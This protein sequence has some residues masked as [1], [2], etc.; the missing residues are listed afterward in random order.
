MAKEFIVPGWRVGWLS[1]VDRSPS[2]PGPQ[3]M[4]EVKAGLKS[5]SQLILGACSL[6]Q[7]AIPRILTPAPGSADQAAL[8]K[9][10]TFYMDLIRTNSEICL[11]EAAKVP[12]LTAVPAKGAMYVM[13]HV[14]I[15]KLTGFT[16]DTDFCARLLMEEN[17][18]V[19]PGQCFGMPNYFR[20]VTCPPSELLLEAWE[21]L[22]LFCAKYRK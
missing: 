8:Q 22:G 10:N 5:L 13:V 16:D 18:F 6:V 9:F 7:R 14:D 11:T 1:I 4:S 15:Q 21:R 17:V 12:E 19:L 3:T 20:L 2:S